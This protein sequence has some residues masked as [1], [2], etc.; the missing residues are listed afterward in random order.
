M[1]WN[2]V[3][4]FTSPLFL[5]CYKR[6][7]DSFK[8]VCELLLINAINLHY[9]HR[10]KTF[11]CKKKNAYVSIIPDRYRSVPV[12]ISDRLSVSIGTYFFRHDFCN[13]E[14]LERSDS[15]SD[16]RRIG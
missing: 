1:Q 4:L 2:G 15:E 16:T 14:G 6:Q 13:G 5:H 3:L 7:E 9:R 12:F 8:I 11:V 10:I